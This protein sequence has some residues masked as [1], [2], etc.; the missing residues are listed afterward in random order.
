MS[1]L[2]LVCP[3]ER[4]T[5]VWTS[6]CMSPRRTQ[7][8]VY[9]EVCQSGPEVPAVLSPCDIHHILYGSVCYKKEPRYT[10]TIK[11]P[12]E[13]FACVSFMQESRGQET[14]QI[15]VLPGFELIQLWDLRQ[16]TSPICK[17]RNV[18]E[19]TRP[20]LIQTS[21]ACLPTLHPTRKGS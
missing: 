16:L 7:S 3:L 19:S 6:R 1:P 9:V 13:V 17:L 18:E 15:W 8:L 10:H 21:S 20:C 4:A 12:M 11:L 5:W 14:G 2:C